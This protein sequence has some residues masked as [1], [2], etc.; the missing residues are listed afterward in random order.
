MLCR[1]IS[2]R[3]SSLMKRLKKSLAVALS[4]IFL[5]GPWQRENSST[6]IPLNVFDHWSGF[7]GASSESTLLAV[8]RCFCSFLHC[9]HQQKPQ[10]QNYLGF[11]EVVGPWERQFLHSYGISQLFSDSWNRRD[12]LVRGWYDL[13]DLGPKISDIRRSNVRGFCKSNIYDCCP[14]FRFYFLLPYGGWYDHCFLF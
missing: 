6:L 1:T 4:P 8:H 9:Y 2:S 10:H 3:N 7:G 12:F 13:R 5:D 14:C 11:P